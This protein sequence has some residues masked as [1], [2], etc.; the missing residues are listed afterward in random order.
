M[1]SSAT[2]VALALKRNEDCLRQVDMICFSGCGDPALPL[3]RFFAEGRLES[4]RWRMRGQFDTHERGFGDENRAGGGLSDEQ[5]PAIG[6]AER[7]VGA[8]CSGARLDAGDAFAV[9]REHEHMAER[10]MGDEQVATLV[11]RKPIRSA[12]AEQ[13]AE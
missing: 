13:R 3:F 10:G 4:G 12:P 1:Y 8:G 5:V 11:Q 6:A 7:E 9:R 2:N